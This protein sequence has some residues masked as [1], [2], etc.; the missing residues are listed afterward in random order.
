MLRLRIIELKDVEQCLILLKSEIQLRSEILPLALNSAGQVIKS[1]IKNIFC[2]V[3]KEINIDTKYGEGHS[4]SEL[5]NL[6]VEKNSKYLHL[7]PEDLIVIRSI[8]TIFNG[9]DCETQI[10]SID[11]ILT[12]IRFLLEKAH[13]NYEKKNRLYI[14]SGLLGGILIATLFS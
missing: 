12:R 11:L 10:N 9:Y 4:L 14:T 3:S 13:D 7:T 1:N 8:S 5:W 6:I 2:S